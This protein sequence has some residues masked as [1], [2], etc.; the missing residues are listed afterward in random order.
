MPPRDFASGRNPCGGN[1]QQC[2]LIDKDKN[3][4]EIKFRVIIMYMYCHQ[5]LVPVEFE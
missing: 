2:T 4:V 5:L 3:N 1:Q